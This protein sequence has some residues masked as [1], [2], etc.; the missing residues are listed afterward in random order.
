MEKVFLSH[1]SNNK[2]YV[3]PIFN[4]FGKDRS[5]FDEMTFESGMKTIEEIFRGID[6][7][8]IFVFFISNDSLNSKWVSEEL[9]YASQK[10]HNDKMRLSQIYPIIIDTNILYS[11]PRIPTFLKTGFS[12]YNLHHINNPKIACKKIESQLVRL[13]INSDLEYSNKINFFYGRELEKKAF[14]DSFDSFDD[15][16]HHKTMKCLIVSGIEG[17]GRKAYARDVLKTSEIMEKY[18]FPFYISLTQSDDI[19]D[20]ISKICDL[21]IGDYSIT[22]I[23]S[24]KTL[25]ERVDVLADLLIQLQKLHEYIFIDDDFCLVKST[26]LVNWLEKVLEKIQPSIVLV[27]TTRIRLNLFKYNKNKDLYCIALNELSK[28]ECSGLLRGYSKMQG[29]PFQLEDIEFF[30]NI[31]TGY[32][33]QIKYCVDLAISEGSIQYIK[34]YSYKIADFPKTNSAKIINTVI[35]KEYQ[36][37]YK[38]FLALLSYMDTVPIT[39][40]NYIIKKNPIY[41][42]ILD[43]L[44]LYSLCKYTGSSGEYIK[45]NAV[46]SDYIQRSDFSL[47]DEIMNILKENVNIFYNNMNSPAYLDY[48]SFSEFV[49]YVKENLKSGKELP[50]KFLYSTIYIKSVIELYNN[51]AYDRVIEIISNLKSTTTFMYLPEESQRVIQFYFCNSL[52]RKN[53]PEFES[54]VI[55]FKDK[56]LYQEYNFLKGFNCRLRGDYKYAENYYKNVLTDNPRHTKARRELVLIYTNLQ[57]YNTALELAEQN[58]RDYPEN[59]YQIQAYFDCLIHNLPLNAQQQEDIEN[60]IESV[61]II[62][63]TKITEMYYQIEAKYAAFIE[64]NYNKASKYILKGLVDF[65]HSFYLNKD[66]FDICRKNHDILGMENALKDLKQSRMFDDANYK[67]TLETRET[68]LDAY[69]GKSPISIQLKLNNLSYLSA[70]AFDN[71]YQAIIEIS[72]QQK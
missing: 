8:D 47:S 50:E 9:S 70:S 10:L 23:I 5:V 63:N 19:T 72:E 4:F 44:K 61:R 45:L 48:L 46:I 24:L 2:D 38:G 34:D 40:I 56:H 62:A 59:M 32:P 55:Y 6:S 33:P 39:L 68:I 11:D 27:I 57:Q 16:G 53:S 17:I 12:A 21:G 26:G 30:S 60:M 54:N 22:D 25:N 41:K 20:L 3:R 58:Y 42:N 13:R 28:S 43:N 64:S 15:F 14:R 71:L 1:S 31:L 37:E 35:D 65:P 49:Y 67:I 29:M 51:K 36:T 69:K 7:S 18:Y 66:Y 52:A